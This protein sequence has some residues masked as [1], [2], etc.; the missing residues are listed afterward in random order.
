MRSLCDQTSITTIVASEPTSSV[1]SATPNPSLATLSALL[2]THVA[3]AEELHAHLQDTEAESSDI[4]ATLPPPIR[5]S[6]LTSMG[7]SP[8]SSLA[9]NNVS[10]AELHLSQATIQQWTGVQNTKKRI[11]EQLMLECSSIRDLESAVRRMADAQPTDV[12]S[13]QL[14]W[15]LRLADATS[16]YD[17]KNGLKTFVGVGAWRS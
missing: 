12:S 9:S 17:T 8:D 13:P 5:R 7:A 11:E 4:E 2:Q 1:L 6:L 15:R 14:T 10:A 16:R 3:R